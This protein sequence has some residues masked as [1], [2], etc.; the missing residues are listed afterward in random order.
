MTGRSHQK[1]IANFYCELAINEMMHTRPDAARPHLAEALAHHRLC[2]RANMLLGDLEVAA[3]RP[4][5][6]I[7]AWK[8]IE[9]QNP[10]YLA[11]VAERLYNAFKQLR[12]GRGGRQPAARLPREVSRRSTCSTWCSRA[13]WRARAPSRPTGWCAT[14]CGACRRCSGSTSCSRRSCWRRRSS[15]AATS[16]WSRSW[17][18]STRAAWRCTSATTAAS[19]RA[20]TTGTARRARRGRPIPR[21][22]PKKPKLPA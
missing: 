18:T 15:A 16:S 3:G 1:E 13:R 17:S 14:S 8:R 2:V 10:Q 6:A 9:S 7:E 19:A 11:L 4:E 21:A 12:Q 20:S 5:A 22:A